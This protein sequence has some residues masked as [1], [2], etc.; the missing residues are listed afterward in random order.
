[1][2]SSTAQSATSIPR[3]PRDDVGNRSVR[4]LIIMAVRVTC[5][6]LMVVIQPFGWYTWLL[7]AA[8]VFL[9]Y[10]AVVLANVGQEGKTVDAVNPERALEPPAAPAPEQHQDVIRI[11][12]DPRPVEAGPAARAASQDDAASARPGRPGEHGST[13]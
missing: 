12:E 1:M 3:A 5:F 9:P 4:Y 10:I 2:K 6:I 7:G 11:A 13:Q 8:A